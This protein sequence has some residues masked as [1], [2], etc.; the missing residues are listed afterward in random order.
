VSHRT[1]RF[2][3]LAEA[4]LTL[5]KRAVPGG[6]TV[7]LAFAPIGRVERLMWA[8]KPKSAM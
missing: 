5:G 4:R 8:L 1:P 7:I 3:K 6:E 2:E